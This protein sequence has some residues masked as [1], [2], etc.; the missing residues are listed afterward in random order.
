MT[1]QWLFIQAQDVWM[2]RDSK[3][4]NAQQN[5]V[6]HS[7]FPP[8]PQTMQGII[9][10]HYLES[11]GVDWKAY[12]AGR[13]RE[14]LYTAVGRP[15]GDNQPPSL[16][17]LRIQGPFVAQKDSENKESPIQRLLPAPV[18]LLYNSE[19][20]QFATM[21]LRGAAQ[22]ATS[23][24]PSNWQPVFHPDKEG[25]APAPGWL[26][27]KQFSDYLKNG[28][29]T[30]ELYERVFEY[31]DRIGLGMSHARRAAETSL[32][33]R[34][35]FVRPHPGVGLL[36]QVN[37]TLF[38]AG[39]YLRIGG[40]SR[41]AHFELLNNYPLPENHTRGNLKVVLLTPAY[42]DGGWQPTAGW[43]QWMGGGSLVSAIVGKPMAISGWDVANKRSKPLRHYVPV[44][45]V[46]YFENARYTDEPF[47]QTPANRGYPEPDFGAMGFGCVAVGSW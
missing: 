27:E 12:A 10:T 26:T 31:E 32:L 43:S 34:A 14:A 17:E 18:D 4:F 38:Q 8:N 20:K 40:E 37:Q 29:A 24:V 30:G 35:R 44:G 45:S 16:G 46:Y 9:R 22:F 25:F 5:F 3:P 28:L 23:G 36:V 19:T 11:Q 21:T 6:A 13:E 41:A 1:G 2:F 33:Y 7:Q 15:Q 42:F 39:G 47:T